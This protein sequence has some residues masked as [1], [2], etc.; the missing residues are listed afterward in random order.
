MA[1]KSQNELWIYDFVIF[2]VVCH[3]VVV[4][5]VCRFIDFTCKSDHS[6]VFFVALMQD[7][8]PL[9]ISVL[10]ILVI[11][12]NLF[13]VLVFVFVAALILGPASVMVVTI[14]I[15]LLKVKIF[16]KQLHFRDDI[17]LADHVLAISLRLS[18]LI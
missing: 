10:P 9:A 13:P 18:T 7:F 15:H 5:F 14:A 16:N 8:A 11:C 6:E 17:S 2:V 3:T 1:I 4:L 12:Y